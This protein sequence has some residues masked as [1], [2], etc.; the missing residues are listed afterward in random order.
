MRV[1]AL[2]PHANPDSVATSLVGFEQCRALARRHAV[3]LAVRREDE[4]PIRR[5]RSSFE[6]VEGVSTAALDRLYEWSV[7]R[8]FRNNYGS[9]ALTAFAYPFAVA[10][11]LA[12]WR[13]FRPQILGRQFDVVLR[14]L[15][16]TSV[17][18]SPFSRLLRRGPVPFVIG[19]VNGG[20]PWPPGFSQA[21]RQREWITGLRTAYRLLPFARSTYRDAAAILVGSSNTYSEFAEYA[22]KLFFVPENGVSPESI[23]G[24]RTLRDS[25]PLELAFVGR[26]VPYKACDL[27]IRGAAP[28]LRHGRARLTVIGD[29]PE[30]SRLT[31]LA[32][33]LGVTGAVTFCGW[34]A[35][36]DALMRLRAADVLVFPSVREFGGGVVFEALAAGTVPVVAAFGGPGDIVRPHVGCAIPLVSPDGVVSAITAI[37]SRLHADR[38]LLFELSRAG[39]HYA[40]ERLTWDA[41][42][43]TVS[44][45]LAWAAGL[46]AKPAVPLPSLD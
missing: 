35:H 38:R 14:V 33:S 20:L 31:S 7:R 32:D 44:E 2:A 19:P 15:P 28:L 43:S 42:A 45:I 39:V 27:A 8:L 6:G 21:E 29:G 36:A 5:F 17:L 12:A 40:R 25:G 26:L 3:T 11:E 37:L 1:L 34:L 10:F 24:E 23:A 41:K 22:E 46:G 30:R 16:V 4:R 9:H 18:P 13:R